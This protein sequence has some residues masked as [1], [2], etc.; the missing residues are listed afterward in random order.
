[1]EDEKKSDEETIFN[2]G[3]DNQQHIQDLLKQASKFYVGGEI[4]LRGKC[5]LEVKRIINSEC[6]SDDEKTFNEM[7]EKI[8]PLLEQFDNL[9]RTKCIRYDPEGCR[10][11]ILRNKDSFKLFDDLNKELNLFEQILRKR[12]SPILFPKT[13]DKRYALANR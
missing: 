3:L 10:Y 5:L 13:P 2:M 1:M 12:L 9:S 8:N 4:R 11:L 6:N 7:V